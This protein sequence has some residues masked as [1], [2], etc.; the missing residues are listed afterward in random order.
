MLDTQKLENET[1]VIEDV[2]SVDIEVSNQEK[3]DLTAP[4]NQI[5][6]TAMKKGMIEGGK[7]EIA[8]E[9]DTMT[10]AYH[11]ERLETPRERKRRERMLLVQQDGRRQKR[12]LARERRKLKGEPEYQE[13]LRLREKFEKYHAA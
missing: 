13:F 3:V 10:L 6:E 4:I 9:G 7:F 2:L 8:S 1:V 5:I 11:F 12:K